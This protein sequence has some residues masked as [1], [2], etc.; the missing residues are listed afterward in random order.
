MC[1]TLSLKFDG[2]LAQAPPHT[3]D[4]QNAPRKLPLFLLF[5]PQH[6]TFTSISTFLSTFLS[7]FPSTFPSRLPFQPSAAYY[8]YIRLEQVRHF[9]FD[10]FGRQPAPSDSKIFVFHNVGG[11]AGTMRHLEMPDQRPPQHRRSSPLEHQSVDTRIHDALRKPPR[12]PPVGAGNPTTAFYYILTDYLRRLPQEERCLFI[13]HSLDLLDSQIDVFYDDIARANW[14]R[15]ARHS[16]FFRSAGSRDVA[17]QATVHR[18]RYGGA[19][20][21]DRTEEWKWKAGVGV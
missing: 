1:P 5:F 21:G 12:P 3:P 6:F 13:L 9:T 20:D 15:R 4:L 10:K 11:L 17:L 7:T 2:V 16:R 14:I 18:R 19:E 8:P